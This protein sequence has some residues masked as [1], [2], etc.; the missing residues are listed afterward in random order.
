MQRIEALYEAYHK[1]LFAYLC[2]L[3]HDRTRAEDLLSETFLAA[4]RGIYSYRG[5]SSE[6]T[7]LFAIARHKWL[8][9]L[10]R[11]KGEISLEVLAEQ[12]IDGGELCDELLRTE[13]AARAL[14]LIASLEP[15][16]RM[17]VNLRMEGRSYAEIEEQTGIRAAS[18]RV[19]DWRARK[20]I[21]EKLIS[22]GY[23]NG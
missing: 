10:R 15:K 11:E 1:E 21:K 18:A 19:L 16:S 9:S 17:V 23:E 12:Y 13:A 20:K 2:S 8:D 6:K 5:K 22:E 14:K 7:W 3:S 4:L